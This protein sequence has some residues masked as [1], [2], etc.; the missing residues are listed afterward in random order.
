MQIIFQD[1]FSSLNSIKSVYQILAEPLQVHKRNI[2]SKDAKSRRELFHAKVVNVLKLVHLP[3]SQEFL[4]KKPNEMSGGQRQRI[5]IARAMMLHPEFIIADEPVSMLDASIK[6]EIIS[7]L[8]ELKQAQALTYIFITHEIA[9]AYHICDLIAVMFN[10]RIVESGPAERIINAPK[11]PYTR[12]LI[13]AVPPL[14]PDRNWNTAEV[15][16]TDASYCPNGCGF[17]HRCTEADSN[18]RK[19]KPKI[20]EYETGHCIACHLYNHAI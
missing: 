6:A 17:Y 1:P 7:L 20:V 5:G 3:N 12:M 18:C 16:E 4:Q 9:L 14:M 8:M 11:H 13:N 15:K 19:E 10:G 2:Y